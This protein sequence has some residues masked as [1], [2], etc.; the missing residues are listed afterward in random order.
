VVE[1][2]FATKTYVV[3]AT[4]PLWMMRP[5][6]MEN[7]RKAEL[8]QG[9]KQDF[10]IKICVVMANIILWF[11]PLWFPTTFMVFFSSAALTIHLVFSE[12]RFSPVYNFICC[13]D[14]GGHNIFFLYFIKR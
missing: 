9:V 13:K 7:K 12:N 5:L 1:Q 3:M 10:M 11:R 4:R 2:G 6:W 8:I 14:A